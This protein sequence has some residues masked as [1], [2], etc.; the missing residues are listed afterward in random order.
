MNN[1]NFTGNLGRDVELRHTTAGDTVAAFSVGVKAGYGEKAS[2]TWARCT[3]FG[4]RAEALA[5]YLVKGQL[6]GVSGEVSLREWEGN[7]GQKRTALEVRVQ[8][9]TLLGKKDSA[10]SPA[11][12]PVQPKPAAKPSSKDPFADLVDDV[13]FN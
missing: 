3:L 5:P 2:T 1:W 8:D 12:A 6:I 9:L 11:P 7:D 10:E 4:K 13:P